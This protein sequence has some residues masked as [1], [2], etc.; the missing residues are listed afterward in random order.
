[1]TSIGERIKAERDARSMT[2]EQFAELAQIGRV[3][4]A[5][6]ETGKAEPSVSVLKRIAIA[7]GQSM[8]YFAGND[9]AINPITH[10]KEY[11]ESQPDVGELDTVAASHTGKTTEEYMR[12][13]AE[14]IAEGNALL[15]KL[16]R[17]QK[18]EK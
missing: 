8:D 15:E 12:R 7:T 16:E 5:R 18:R 6:Y 1:M 11:L 4:L 14:Q 9:T 3:N 17:A 10:P 2:Q 13:L